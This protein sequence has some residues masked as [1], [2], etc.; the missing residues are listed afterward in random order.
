MDQD[1]VR[2][3]IDITLADRT[4][5]ALLDTGSVADL[6]SEEVARHLESKGTRPVEARLELRL[7]D[8]SA[9]QVRKGYTILGVTTDKTKTQ[10]SFAYCAPGLTTDI[11]LGIRTIRELNL[12][13][14]IAC[15]PKP[16]KV[17]NDVGAV[18]SLTSLTQPQDFR[19]KQ[20][21]QREMSLFDAFEG[22]TKLIEHVIRLKPDALPIKQRYYPRNP[23]MQSIINEEVASMLRDGV[24]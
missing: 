17:P 1:D 4:F 22:K 3:F 19:L 16:S 24:I 12:T 2:P 21:L 15:P 10:V 13:W 7:A 6:V 18:E 9:R 23:A 14:C 11:V 5:R 20:F 8:G